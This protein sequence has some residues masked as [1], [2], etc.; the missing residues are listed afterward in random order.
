MR[1]TSRER[2]RMPLLALVVGAVVAVAGI[3]LLQ[4]IHLI[5]NLSFRGEFSWHEAPA[6]FSRIGWLAIFVPAAG[7]LIIG[8][9]ARFI[10]PEV[11]GHGIPEAMQGVMV[12]QSRIPLRVAILKPLATALSIGT[13]GPFGAEGPIIATGGG[14]GSLF[15]QWIPH[16][17]VERK[18]MLAAGAAAGMTAVFGTP[19]AGVLLAVELL[20]FEFRARSLL[21]VAMAAGSAMA[22]RGLLDQPFPMLPLPAPD[23]PG[24]MIALG[25]VIIGLVCG[26]LGTGMTVALHRIECLY[27]RLPIPRMWW[28]AIGGL[29]VGLIGWLDPRTLGSGYFNLRALLDGDM[30]VSAIATLA[31]LKFLSWSLYLGSGTAGGTLAPVMTVGG[32]SAALVAHALILLP[33]FK[34]MP[35]GIAALVGMAA[36]FAGMSRAFLASVAFAFEAT[37]STST[38]GPLLLGCAFAVLISRLLMKESIMTEKLARDGVRVPEDYEPDLFATTPV[39][40]VMNRNPLTVSPSLLL[41]DLLVKAGD[42]AEPLNKAR[43]FP[44]VGED[45]ILRGIISRSELLEAIRSDSETQVGEVAIRDPHVIHPDESLA[46][47]ANRML[48]HGIGRLPV[49]ERG[50]RPVL[51]GLITRKEILDVRRRRLQEEFGHGLPPTSPTPRQP[52]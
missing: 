17:P 14:I 36:V 37:H 6:T 20:L 10:A 21:P 22:V 25:A 51:V 33:P 31:V 13:G 52:A 2:F 43:I 7:G 39:S 1:S 48:L 15:G 29:L 42:E 38:F 26:A 30:V 32:T 4:L 34:D 46:D 18:V 50:A 41:S 9:V 3:G 16:S 27:E 45:R 19:L 40:A 44:I 35:I 24:P 12:N 11:S 28:P 49:V 5:T 8:L 47:A 23:A